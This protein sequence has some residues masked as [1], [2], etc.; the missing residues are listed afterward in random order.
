MGKVG[1]VW[2]LAISEVIECLAQRTVFGSQ[3]CIE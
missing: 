2:D 1:K 3:N